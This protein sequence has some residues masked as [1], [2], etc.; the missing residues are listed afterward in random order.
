M[1]YNHVSML[2]LIIFAFVLE[3][4]ATPSTQ[5][6][7]PSTD[8]QAFLK[9][10]IGWDIYMNTFGNGLISNGGVTMG[11][12]PS[13]KLGLEIGIDYRDGS[14]VHGNPILFNAKL[15][16]AENTFSNFMPAIAIGGYDFG[17]KDNV[18]NYNV[19]YGLI[20]KNIW[21]LGRL[22]F[23]GYKGLG[24]DELWMSSKGTV[25]DAGVFL[26]WDRVI[27]ELTD[28]L[29]LAVD[30]QSGNNSYGA[31]S[32]G[33]GWSFASNVGVIIGYDIYNDSDI[34][35]PTFTMQ[36]DINLF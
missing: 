10:H 24:P 16:L 29:W 13:E 2:S 28:K 17:V 25:R 31:L 5:I 15:G 12:I 35:E 33:A 18:S 32:F 34:S 1:R 27:S 30:F 4:K 9:P 6:W 19:T 23:G 36:F 14:G 8:V 11:V 22:S 21:K 20:S 26:S 3:P 7:I